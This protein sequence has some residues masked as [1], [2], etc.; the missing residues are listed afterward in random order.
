[1]DL[2]SVIVPVYN[3]EKYLDRCVESIVNQTYKNLEIILVNDGSTDNSGQI[4]DVWAEK[5]NRIRVIHQSNMG[6]GAARN[7]AL[8]IAK[9]DYIAFVDSDDYIA[10]DM[11]QYLHNLMETETDIAECGY[12]NVDNDREDFKSAGNN[13]F[14]C[15]TKKAMEYHI[16]DKYFKQMPVTKLY[17]KKCIESVRFP[18]GTK[19]DDEYFTYKTIGKANK[20][21]HSTKICYAYRQ[22]SSSVM[23]SANVEK[24][25]QAIE[26]RVER[27][28]YIKEYFP[29]LEQLCLK[30]VWG[31]CIYQYQVIL[32]CYKKD[33]VKAI[34]DYIKRILD[35]NT[36]SFDGLPFKE[37]IW[38]SIA[39]ISL[40]FTCWIR[41]KLGIGL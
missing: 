15:D 28:K 18:V 30:N 6:G 23:H 29:E 33:D 7:A 25:I 9:G 37:K 38:F 10:N 8:E 19:I 32:K 20:L 40:H 35:E 13:I 39:K 14:V 12:V 21:V 31:T 5:D 1:M 11:Y 17:K 4:C 24:C 34:L 16:L 36:L 2:I 41:N 3:V 22:H 27:Y 26:S